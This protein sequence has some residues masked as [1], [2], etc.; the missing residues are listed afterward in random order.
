MAV[1][2]LALTILSICVKKEYRVNENRGRNYLPNGG[3]GMNLPSFSE[4]SRSE[5]YPNYEKDEIQL[6]A[7]T[8]NIYYD[9]VNGE[10][11]LLCELYVYKNEQL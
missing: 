6:M 5:S 3:R 9:K 2:S 8:K 10:K 4:G 7:H 1:F 11:T